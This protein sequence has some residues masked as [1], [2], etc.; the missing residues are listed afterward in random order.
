[1]EVMKTG[2]VR[3]EIKDDE[4]SIYL[5]DH[6]G[7]VEEITTRGLDVSH[8]AR[9]SEEHGSAANAKRAPSW[10]FASTEPL[11]ENGS[12]PVSRPD[13]DDVGDALA[14]R[15]M[16]SHL[17]DRA[18]PDV[19]PRAFRA[20]DQEPGL[21]GDLVCPGSAPVDSREVTGRII[22]RGHGAAP[23]GRP[24]I[25]GQGRC[26]GDG[27]RSSGDEPKMEKRSS[28]SHRLSPSARLT[29][30][31]APGRLE[32]SSRASFN[33]TRAFSLDPG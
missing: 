22:A 16:P 11:K 7:S 21:V 32:R 23:S 24:M 1:M 30:G 28:G 27:E 19:P 15:T 26:G 18:D 31:G 25:R 17:H 33:L 29:S 4:E 2:D 9:E 10:R 14:A 6:P 3:G 12:I 13:T 20:T 8:I 5:T